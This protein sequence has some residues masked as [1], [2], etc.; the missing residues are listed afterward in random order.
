MQ[1]AAGCRLGASWLESV[2][3]LTAEVRGG[4]FVVVYGN[5]KVKAVAVCVQQ[6]HRLDVDTGVGKF[7][8]HAGQG[9]WF[10]LDDRFDDALF[11]EANTGIGEDA[12]C[13][14]DVVCHQARRAVVSVGEEGECF[15]MNPGSGQL[16]GEGGKL[17]RPIGQVNCELSHNHSLRLSAADRESQGTVFGYLFV[18]ALSW[19]VGDSTSPD[20]GETVE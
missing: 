18:S 12:T 20:V 8:G 17:S 4:Q 10:V 1:D 5:R 14:C 3:V 15:D 7:L 11:F 6:V 19:Y 2:A 13:D 16:I 9:V